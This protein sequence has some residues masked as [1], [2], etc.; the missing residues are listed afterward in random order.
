LKRVKLIF[1]NVIFLTATALILRTVAL[2]FQVYLSNKIGAEG[3]GLFQLIISVYFLAITFALAGIRLAAT[4]LV[5]EELGTGS[6]KGAKKAVAICLKFSLGLSIIVGLLLFFGAELIG[7]RWLSDRRTI[8]SLR[9]LAFTLPLM[10][11][12]SVYSGYFT[13]VRRAIKAASIQIAEQFIR[14]PVAIIILALFLPSDLEYA[15]VA[16]V[17]GSCLGELASFIM[18]FLAY[19]ADVRRFQGGKPAS[20]NLFSRMLK[21]TLPVAFSAYIT[22]SLRTLQQLLIPI[23]LKKSGSSSGA[24]LATYG[25]I[26]G[27]VVPVLMFP[28][29]ILNSVSDLIIPELA[30]CQAT[31]SVNRLHYILTRVFN[32]GLLSSVFVMFIFFRY[33][34]ELGL[35]IYQ[36][37]AAAYFLRIFSPL[38]VILYMDGIVDGML[39]GIGQQVSSMRYNILESTVSVVL[40]YFLLP[41]YAINGYIFT[42]FLARTLNFGLSVYRLVKV[43]KVKFSLGIIIKSL[44]SMINSI[45]ITNLLFMGIEK[46]F[47]HGII[48]LL[49]QIVCA[50]FVYYFLLRALNCITDEDLQWFWS[51][52]SK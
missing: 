5:A 2:F 37:E 47:S 27:M 10:A 46:Y 44:I 32:L 25:T 13:A 18:L 22:S 19:K 4:R 51:I 12:S 6:N 35:S 42:V 21:I 7:L 49:T 11:V 30:E 52:F 39:K 45:I 24:A 3:I 28:S 17:I 36:S 43:V 38:V 50:A 1:I 23:G 20:N 26:Q 29:A 41:R 33:S 34:R 31:G 48:E 16:V 40:I 8:L 15:C 9:L 14:I